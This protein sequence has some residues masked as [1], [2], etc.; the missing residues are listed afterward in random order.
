MKIRFSPCPPDSSQPEAFKLQ[1]KAHRYL[2]DFGYLRWRSDLQ[3]HREEIERFF[4][5]NASYLRG[6]NSF[7]I[8]R[9]KD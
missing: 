7:P 9:F 3:E 1:A 4:R 6:E 2:Q 5:V 8:D